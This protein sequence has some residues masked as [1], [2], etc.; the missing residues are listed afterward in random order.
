M[1]ETPRVKIDFKIGLAYLLI[2]LITKLIF[3]H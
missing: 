1:A 3:G 2:H